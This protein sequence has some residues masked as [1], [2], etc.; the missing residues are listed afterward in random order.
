MLYWEKK[1]DEPFR[2]VAIYWPNDGKLSDFPLPESK[3]ILF[4]SL[5]TLDRSRFSENQ[6]YQGNFTRFA[7]AGAKDDIEVLETNIEVRTRY[8][9]HAHS[10]LTERLGEEVEV[11]KVKCVR[12]N[13]SRHLQQ[14]MDMLTT[15][16]YKE[17][18]EEKLA[19]DETQLD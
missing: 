10:M 1:M 14:A 13:S 9:L 17:L 7:M 18:L 11:D 2:A 6:T 15:H 12:M 3:T 19:K 16:Y 8:V 4:Y 5:M